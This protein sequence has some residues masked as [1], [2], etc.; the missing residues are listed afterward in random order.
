MLNDFMNLMVNHSLLQTCKQEYEVEIVKKD[1]H[2][3]IHVN[4]QKDYDQQLFQLMKKNNQCATTIVQFQSKIDEHDTPKAQ[5]KSLKIHA[6][7]HESSY[8]DLWE[9]FEKLKVVTD[10]HQNKVV[11]ATNQMQQKE[12]EITDLHK[13]PECQCHEYVVFNWHKKTFS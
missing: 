3:Q 10:Q 6:Q 12:K 1:R 5:I 4:R 11:Q 9:E 8:W 7:K 2:I 13:L